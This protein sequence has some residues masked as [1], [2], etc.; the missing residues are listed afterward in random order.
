MM[1]YL[2]LS[3]SNTKK[4]LYSEHQEYSAIDS[5]V[6]LCSSLQEWVFQQ[7]V[8]HQTVADNSFLKAT[9]LLFLPMI[10]VRE[11]KNP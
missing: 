6:G 1:L 10:D 3:D 11:G 4:S 9:T 8:Y 2:G 5:A 7:S